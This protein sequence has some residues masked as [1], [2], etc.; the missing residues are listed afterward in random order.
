MHMYVVIYPDGWA[1]KGPNT[2]EDRGLYD[3]QNEAIIEATRI[4]KNNG[5]GEVRI[6]GTDGKFR[7]SNTISC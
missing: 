7:D 3:T 2:K 4:V 5:G 6:Q 1:V